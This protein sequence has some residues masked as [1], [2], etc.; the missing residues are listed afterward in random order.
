M[1]CPG[2]KAFMGLYKRDEHCELYVVDSTGSMWI[3]DTQSCCTK[4]G[5]ILEPAP[6]RSRSTSCKGVHIDKGYAFIISSSGNNNGY[7]YMLDIRDKPIQ[8]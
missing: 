3:V 5:I 4:D 6:E 1:V 2:N 7:I 8:Y